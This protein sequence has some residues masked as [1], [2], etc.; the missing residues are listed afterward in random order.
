MS[1]K[2]AREE[3]NRERHKELLRSAKG[4]RR[5]QPSLARGGPNKVTKPAILIVCE[6]ENTEPSYF[7][8]FRLSS[9]RIYPVGEGYNTVSLVNRA[10][11]LKDRHT[12]TYDQVWCVYDK[13]DYSANDFNQAITIASANGFGLAYSNQAFEYWLI[14]HFEDHQGGG[15]HRYD[16]EGKI[17]GYI[18]PLGA[19]FDGRGSKLV[20][21]S[22]FSLLMDIDPQTGRQRVL[23]AI[24]RA[25]R[26]YYR[27]DHRS[28]ATEESSTT[29]FRLVEELLKYI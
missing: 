25:K 12:D 18:Q 11:D 19:R 5:G 24:E 15:C 16:Y 9:A 8:R 21:D 22:F 1:N 2:K 10:I 4:S 23:L 7:S 29:V 28:P 26:I 14:L 17:N 20:D 6:G 27:L 13:D 3:A